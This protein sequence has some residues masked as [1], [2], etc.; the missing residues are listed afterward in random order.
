MTLRTRLMPV[1]SPTKS[2][3]RRRAN[4]WVV[5]PTLLVSLLSI[6]C[7]AQRAR[8]AKPAQP[9]QSAKQ[10]HQELKLTPE[11]QRG[12]RLLKTAEADAAGLEPDMRA[13]VLWRASY[14]YV[15][16]DPKKAES[17]AKDS[18]TASEAIEDPSDKDQCGPIGSAGDIKSW[19]QKRVLS[20]LT[21]KEKAGDAEQLLPNT[22][23]P[24][25]DDITRALVKHYVKKNDTS[26]AL[27]LLSQD[28]DSEQYPFD[29]AAD[30]ILAM[31]PEQSAD[32]MT[33]FNQ[34]LNNFAQHGTTNG[35]GIGDLGTLV[36]RTWA[37][38]PPSVVL[39][40]IDKMVEEAKSKESH[41]HLSMASDKGIV[42][43]NST[44]ELRLFQLLPV[45]EELDKD[46]AERLTRE[47]TAIQA[48]LAKYPK[49][50]DSLTSQG[51]IYSYGITDDDSSQTS[52]SASR[53]AARQQAEQQIVSA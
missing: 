38:I 3:F 16:I 32:R 29:A 36:E 28:A 22:A 52:Q 46:K 12:L 34:A 31:G 41:S 9:S 50:M 42:S 33:V 23:A 47:N 5:A 39:E 25:R 37:R 18:F 13:F 4:F 19:I 51:N 1:F 43:L 45:L 35:I 14:A 6:A 53:E 24:V 2:V 15:P 20:D 7:R 8:S 49:G 26:R 17:L 10:P 48:Q 11:Q 21:Q 30:L 44:Y 27:L 40:A